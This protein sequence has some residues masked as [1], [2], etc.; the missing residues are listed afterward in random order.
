MLHGNKSYILYKNESLLGL[1]FSGKEK[2]R[3]LTHCSVPHPS[4]QNSLKSL[5]AM[6]AILGL[7]V[8][9]CAPVVDR[10]LVP[11]N[12]FTDQVSGFWKVTAQ[13]TVKEAHL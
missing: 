7:S 13:R 9:I 5:H 12:E 8:L 2:A 3:W 11:L 6:Q 10:K 4:N 1:F